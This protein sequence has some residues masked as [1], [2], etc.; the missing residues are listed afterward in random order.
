[1]TVMMLLITFGIRMGTTVYFE[2]ALGIVLLGFVSTVAL[3]RFL[4]PGEVIE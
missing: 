1:M 3:A 4:M 2:L